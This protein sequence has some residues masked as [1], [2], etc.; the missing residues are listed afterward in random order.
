MTTIQS[1]KEPH[2]AFQCQSGHGRLNTIK[3]TAL[4]RNN[5]LN[6]SV[7]RLSEIMPSENL[8]QLKCKALKRFETGDGC[9][10]V[11]N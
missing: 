10:T 3:V 9:N 6:I 7:F 11:R 4:V 2:R 1:T 5:L 8:L